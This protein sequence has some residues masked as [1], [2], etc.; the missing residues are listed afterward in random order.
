MYKYVYI[1]CLSELIFIFHF[2]EGTWLKVYPS[3]FYLLAGENVNCNFVLTKF[4][5][6]ILRYL[7][8]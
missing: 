8:K 2:F 1:L 6:E 4:R 7:I 3:I 5:E